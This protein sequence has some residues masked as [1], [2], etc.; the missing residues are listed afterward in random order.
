MNLEQSEEAILL[1]QASEVATSNEYTTENTPLMRPSNAGYPLF[2]QVWRLLIEP[3]FPAFSSSDT[4]YGK[5][6][7]RI[8]SICSG[9]VFE[10]AIEKQLLETYPAHELVKQQKLTFK[11]FTGSADFVLLDKNS[12]SLVVVECKSVN[13]STKREIVNEKLLVNNWGYKTQLSIY[14]EAAVEMC[15]QENIRL[16]SVVPMWYVWSRT[17]EKLFIVDASKGQ[18]KVDTILCAEA[19]V[20]VYEELATI[21]QLFDD[22]ELQK[23]AA[24]AV[25]ELPYD[26]DFING[27]CRGCTPFH[28]SPFTEVFFDSEGYC[29]PASECQEIL[30]GFL[31]IA[32]ANTPEI[33]TQLAKEI[34]NG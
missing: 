11:Y 1:K 31:Q 3:T 22:G 30:I 6:L 27:Y 18:T 16:T 14:T 4:D 34:L 8:M 9:H 5:R 20:G 21:K 15:N 7:K 29:K 23:A 33:Y 12:G 24:M 10:R 2:Q 17:A 13:K 19:A 32:K 25:A 28:F 26:K